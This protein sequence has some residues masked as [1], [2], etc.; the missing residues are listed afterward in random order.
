MRFASVQ[1][2]WR[3]DR[4]WRVCGTE[5]GFAA[6]AR[7]SPF[8]KAGAQACGQDVA[9]EFAGRAP[10]AKGSA[11]PK[12]AAEGAHSALYWPPILECQLEWAVQM[13]DD[14]SA[15]QQ[16][17]VSWARQILDVIENETE[18]ARLAEDL[19]STLGDYAAQL[20]PEDRGRFA[21]QI[22]VFPE[23]LAACRRF[24]QACA[25]GDSAGVAR[26][27][28]EMKRLSEKSKL[29]MKFRG[30][31]D[32]AEALAK[33]TDLAE[34]CAA[35][36]SVALDRTYGSGF[37]GTSPFPLIWAISARSKPLERVQLMLDAGART[38]LRAGLGETV[39]H[40]MARMNRKG[41]VR[42]A[43][44]KLL[45]SRGADVHARNLH[46]VTPLAAA[47]DEGSEE[48]VTY[49]LQAG[50]RVGQIDLQIAAE[51]PV[52][53]KLVLDHIAGDR[54]YFD[55]RAEFRDW[56]AEEI[57][58]ARH[59]HSE[60]VQWGVGALRLAERVEQLSASSEMVK[61][62]R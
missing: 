31:T 55:L 30:L 20:M 19:V 17:T 44:L 24:D 32:A 51:N 25:E 8:E 1:D 46:G 26:Q 16:L 38:N 18:D 59:H 39:L 34:F 7:M 56:L 3:D 57:E 53:L 5:L 48:D 14:L 42:L 61:G 2:T 23:F 4:G 10:M 36:P 40:A 11:V 50:A 37:S 60:A 9:L 15:D 12:F 21:E 35:L 41:R 28:A 43:I 58:R 27:K 52:R 33:A 22:S 13:T 54:R 29:A 45:I 6:I 47:L 62:L 49:F